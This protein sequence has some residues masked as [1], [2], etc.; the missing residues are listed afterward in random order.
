MSYLSKNQLAIIQVLQGAGRLTSEE[1]FTRAK[2]LLPNHRHNDVMSV[3]MSRLVKRGYITRVAPGVFEISGR[4]HPDK[5]QESIDPNQLEL[6]SY[7]S[8]GENKA[9]QPSP[10]R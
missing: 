3:Y 2:V 9:P 6:F 5:P 1:I 8:D 10:M 7:T 4:E